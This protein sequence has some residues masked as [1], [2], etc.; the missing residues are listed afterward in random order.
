ML[1]F[2]NKP[3]NFHIQYSRI[4]SPP[5]RMTSGLLGLKNAL[6]LKISFEIEPRSSAEVKG[7]DEGHSSVVV[8][9]YY[10]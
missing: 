2:F 7:S 3:A 4:K 5:G 8:F 1:D 10:N 9:V 6:I